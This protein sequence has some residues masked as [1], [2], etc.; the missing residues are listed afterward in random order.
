MHFAL[1]QGIYLK[2]LNFCIIHST[3]Y[4]C[5][6]NQTGNHTLVKKNVFARKKLI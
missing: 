2:L 1:E 6:K 5:N 4:T 3:M